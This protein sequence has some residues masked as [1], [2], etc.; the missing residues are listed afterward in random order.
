M[1]STRTA[2]FLLQQSWVPDSFSE[3]PLEPLLPGQ[4]HSNS[5]SLWWSGC[6]FLRRKW[7]QITVY[8]LL[9]FTR[10]RTLT[11]NC[12]LGL[13]DSA[14]VV[15]LFHLLPWEGCSL[16]F[17]SVYINEVECCSVAEYQS[18]MAFTVWNLLVF[19]NAFCWVFWDQVETIEILH[20]PK[21]IKGKL[22]TSSLDR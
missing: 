8:P 1:A 14:S 17:P 2:H 12:A 11:H 10:H 16:S 7:L 18:P 4:R 22:E 3:L 21:Q 15:L 20:D 5:T 19:T 13:W 6:W 9:V